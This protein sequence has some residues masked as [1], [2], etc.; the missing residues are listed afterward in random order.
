MEPIFKVGEK[1]RVTKRKFDNSD[2]K[3]GYVNEMRDR[4]EGRIVTICHVNPN[5]LMGNYRVK[6][7]CARYI[8]EEDRD[9]F[10]WSSG[11]FDK[12]PQSSKENVTDKNKDIYRKIR[13]ALYASLEEQG[14]NIN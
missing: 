5:V 8:I 10:S 14:V 4:F 12:L 13:K 6:D 1:V 11:M 9:K 7:D 2:Y 3:Y